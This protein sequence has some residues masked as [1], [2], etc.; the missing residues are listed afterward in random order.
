MRAW[1][2]NGTV[3]ETLA[4]RFNDSNGIRH[5]RILCPYPARAVFNQTCGIGTVAECFY[6]A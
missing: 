2:E 5:D 4:V 6:C 1:V 3:P